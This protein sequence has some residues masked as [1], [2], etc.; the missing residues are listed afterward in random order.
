MQVEATG[1][2]IIIGA[3][4]LTVGQFPIQEE[5]Y[6]IAVDGGLSYCGVLGIEPDLILGDF[7][8]VSEQEKQAV[9]QLKQEIPERIVQL[10]PE[11]DDTDMLAALRL[12]LEKGFD[13]FHIYAG[14]GGR[15]DHTLANIQ[16][17]LFLKRNGATGYLVDGNGMILVICNE[18]VSFKEGMEGYLSLFTLGRE[19]KGVTIENMKYELSGYTMTN[20]YPI[21]ISNEFVGKAASVTVEDGEVVCILQY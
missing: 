18:K 19:A 9:L 21:G 17:L 11:K 10:K 5:D 4:D 6:V 20:D 12:G 16:C 15:L 2:C 1:K 8:S 14:T 7:D 13:T 3:G